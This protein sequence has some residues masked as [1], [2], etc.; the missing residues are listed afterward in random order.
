MRILVLGA[1][2][3]TGRLIVGRAMAKGHSVVA[4]V[5]SKN[6]AVTLASAELVE[7]DARTYRR[8]GD[9]QYPPVHL[10]NRR[11]RGR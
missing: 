7:G 6:K 1:T 2:G 9:A 5:R 8:D 3:A 4:L 11:G 10:H